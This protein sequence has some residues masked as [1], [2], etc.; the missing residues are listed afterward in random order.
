MPEA[1]TGDIAKELGK[2][3][4]QMT[5]SDKAV[6]FLIYKCLH[7]YTH[8]IT[9]KYVELGNQDK[10]RYDE[11]MKV[12]I[13][14]GK[15]E[16]FKA[17]RKEKEEKE[18]EEA[19]AESDLA[20]PVT[21]GKRKRKAKDP[22]APKR[23]R[24]AF[25]YFTQDYRG[26]ISAANPGIGLPALGKLM[27]QS[28]AELPQELKSVYEEKAKA[29]RERY[30]AEMAAFANQLPPSPELNPQDVKKQK[31]DDDWVEEDA[32]AL[33]DEIVEKVSEVVSEVEDIIA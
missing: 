1:K 6:S 18:N 29:D 23:P 32:S 33:V 14:S 31:K 28:W 30:S 21:E 10:S 26:K 2:Q 16:L 17:S 5:E 13:G 11:E 8:W 3:W 7:L 25:L 12:Y 27:G 4:A 15:Q 22:N 20:Q 9:K 19:G 24:A